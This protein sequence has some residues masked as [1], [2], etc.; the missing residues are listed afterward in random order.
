MKETY[1][2]RY[3][4]VFILLSL[5]I[6]LP[7]AV[8]FTRGIFEWNLFYII[9]GLSIIVSYMFI[10]YIIRLYLLKSRKAK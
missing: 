7:S 5:T 1:F 6:S 3:K 8:F 4:L 2:E 9:I 10:C